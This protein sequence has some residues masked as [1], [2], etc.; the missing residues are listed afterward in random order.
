MYCGRRGTG[1]DGIFGL[2]ASHY[3]GRAKQTVR[4]DEENVDVLCVACHKL[5]GTDNKPLY[6]KWKIEQ[7]GQDRFDK[8]NLL[9]HTT[10]KKDYKLQE[11]I[12]TAKLKELDKK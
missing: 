6:K 2:Q 4:F 7:L 8:L 3:F 9:A 5:L 10:G 12:W 1:P 11:I